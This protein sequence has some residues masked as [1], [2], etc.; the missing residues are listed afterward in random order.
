M[1][2]AKEKKQKS[3]D[4]IEMAEGDE[5]SEGGRP[6]GVDDAE[7]AGDVSA[8]S[9]DAESVSEIDRLQAENDD[10]R[11]KWLRA[12][13]DLDNFRKRTAREKQKEIGYARIGILLPLLEVLDDLERALEQGGGERGDLHKGVE[14][15]RGKFVDKLASV[16]VAPFDTVGEAFDPESME[17]VAA[18][19][20]PGGEA[21][22][23]VGEIRKGYRLGDRVI[24]PAQVSVSAE[25]PE[26]DGNEV[27]EKS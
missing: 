26:P 21:N 16:G 7:S 11:D 20:A 13:A 27:D 9:G 4:E 8:R 19:P 1:S 6:G 18:V 5:N 22:R 12:A 17:A 10:L 24:R 14:M 25:A 23:V 3:R 2:K 15:I